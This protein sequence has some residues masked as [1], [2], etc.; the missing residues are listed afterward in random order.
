MESLV[1]GHC[2]RLDQTVLESFNGERLAIPG[3]PRVIVDC[4]AI[5]QILID[6]IDLSIGPY[7]VEK[8]GEHL[9]VR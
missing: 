2:P 6:N 3:V 9:L 7:I 5:C 4:I 1:G 8:V